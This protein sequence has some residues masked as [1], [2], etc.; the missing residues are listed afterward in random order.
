MAKTVGSAIVGKLIPAIMKAVGKRVVGVDM[1]KVNHI[2]N[3]ISHGFD[4]LSTVD[5]VYS[6]FELLAGHCP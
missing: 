5:I 4:K 6:V 1:N 2:I 3:K